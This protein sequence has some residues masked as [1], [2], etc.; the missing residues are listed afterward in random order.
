MDTQQ[1]SWTQLAWIEP[2]SRW[3]LRTFLRRNL[4]VMTDSA[5]RT[6]NWGVLA[7]DVLAIYLLLKLV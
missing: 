3:M 7:I 6:I 1:N 2:Q 4:E 5:R